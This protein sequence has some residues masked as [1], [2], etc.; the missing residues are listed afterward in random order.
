LKRKETC[1]T[2]ALLSPPAQYGTSRGGKKEKEKPPKSTR[3]KKKKESGE[4]EISS[5]LL[6]A[7]KRKRTK[8]D[9]EEKNLSLL[10]LAPFIQ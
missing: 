4:G 9:K 5:T 2:R 8:E 10:P 3:K 7:C 6:H 1:E